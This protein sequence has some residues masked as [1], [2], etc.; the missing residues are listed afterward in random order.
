MTGNPVRNEIMRAGFEEMRSEGYK[1][2][3][4]DKTMKTLLVLG[5]SLGARTINMGMIKNLDKIDMSGIQV[6]W[7]CG[8]YYHEG[9]VNAINK[10][11][12]T[13]VVLQDFIARMDLAYAVADLIISRAGAITI[14]ELSYAGKPAILVPS[15]NVAEDHQTKN[16][17]ALVNKSAAICIPDD[18]AVEKMIPAAFELMK[19]EESMKKMAVN[20]SALKKNDPAGKIAEEVI[21]LIKDNYS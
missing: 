9:A 1:F 16:A 15:P 2:F 5:G 21:K 14:A 19:D 4:L 7:Q 3:R 13:R 20:I 6:L 17:R 10:S 18:K 11:G 12:T 8:K